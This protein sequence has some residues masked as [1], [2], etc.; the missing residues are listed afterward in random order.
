MTLMRTTTSRLRRWAPRGPTLALA[1]VPAHVLACLPAC[2][3]A[4]VLASVLAAPLRAQPAPASAEATNPPAIPP[5][6]PAAVLVRAFRVDGNSLLDPA[7]LQATLQPWQGTRSLAELRQAAQAV[8]GLYS[9][10]GYGAVV[11]YLPPQPVADGTVTVVVVE[12]K[13]SRITVQGARRLSPE[14]VRAAL[15]TLVEGATP[16]VRRID[17]ELQIANENPA[18]SVGV[19]LGPGAAPGEVAATVKIEEQPVQRFTLALD[20]SGND[21]T[22][23]YRLSLGWLH[24]D[25]SGHDDILNLQVQVSPTKFS[26]V[27]VL[28]AGYRL[29][30]VRALAALDLF[31]AYS[32]VDGGI[33]PS[34]AGDL[35][36][37]GKGR[38]LGARGIAYLPRWG[39]VDQRLTL[40][41]ESRDYRNDCSVAGLPAGA[42]GPAGASV[43]VQPLTLEYAAQT[44]G[45]LPAALNIALAH[46][47]A[48]GG[49]HGSSADFDAARPGAVPRYTVVRGGGQ[50]S[51]PVADDWALGGRLAGQ[52]TRDALV[53]GEQFGLGGASTVRGYAD[54][55]LA[56]DR[57][58]V[59]S[60][61]LT[62]P[63]LLGGAGGAGGEAGGRTPGGTAGGG[64][65]GGTAGG[66]ADL[67]LLAF[68][69]AGQVSNVDNLACRA[70]QTRCTLSSVGIGARLGWGVVQGRLFVA[71]ALQDAAATRTGDWRTHLTLTANF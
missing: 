32:D 69:D 22:G 1:R 31:A 7:L 33:Q 21:A 71:R 66:A 56:G 4:G 37:A 10:A 51:T 55:E 36:F 17:A 13:L 40:A 61:E 12:G 52:F 20:N 45:A 46:N 58:L 68:V 65:P 14:R 60:I 5:A 30:L 24:A 44:G 48:L 64:S 67:R 34:A 6:T 27:Q 18:R 41:I 28:S 26:A 11:A 3:L 53:P 29:P 63:R 23:L 49:Q 25:I 15:P 43:R 42:C 47:L 19:L 2:V 35:R 9:Q 50:I 59:A 38:I 8:Q 62:T 39:E 57:G 16:R 70:L 54:R